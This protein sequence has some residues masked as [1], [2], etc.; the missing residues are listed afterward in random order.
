MFFT[1]SFVVGLACSSG[2]EESS[3]STSSTASYVSRSHKK[4]LTLSLDVTY[5]GETIGA[6]LWEAQVKQRLY[7]DLEQSRMLLKVS[8]TDSVLKSPDEK[9][10]K[11]T[12]RVKVQFKSASTNDPSFGFQDKLG[13]GWKII[14]IEER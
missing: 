14:K 5:A 8:T 1:L 10:T 11:T 12:F 6:S 7:G 4:D 3:E 2:S 9:Q 13:Q